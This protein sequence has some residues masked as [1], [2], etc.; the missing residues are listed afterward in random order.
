MDFKSEILS[1]VYEKNQEWVL[2]LTAKDIAHILNS[3]AYVPYMKKQKKVDFAANIGKQGE[4]KFEGIISQYMSNDY[5][6]TNTSK[7]AHSGDFFLTW[8]SPKTHKIYKILIDVKN[9]KRTSIS[10]KEVHKLHNDLNVNVVHA[11]FMISLGAK[12]TGFSKTIEI[13]EFVLDTGVKIP[14][15]FANI[16]TPETICEVLKLLFRM[17]EINDICGNKQH[18]LENLFY[19]INQL[20]DDIQLITD[21]RNVL[22][23]SKNKIDV[24]LNAI[25]H[26]LMT[27]EYSL[28]GKITKINNT[29]MNYQDE[30]KMIEP[31]V[32]DIPLNMLENVKR[33]FD[34]CP[35]V[36]PYLLSIFKIGWDSSSIDIPKKKWV[37]I[38]NNTTITIRLFKIMCSVMIPVI[39]DD[40]QQHI[41]AV[42]NISSKLVRNTASGL[43]IKITDDT[44]TSV[45]CIC[46]LIHG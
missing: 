41:N 46:K 13:T 28:A 39:T 29:I 2:G 33:V 14:V 4:N 43:D 37:L 27:C 12:I 17:V 21:T 44:I 35:E 25:M 42:R 20:N 5:K 31:E 11:G 3:V 6:L 23:E 32:N 40:M 18:D 9:Y 30:L 45:I 10:T 34:V 24:S 16:K 36:Y 1:H 26:K 7:K 38:K 8:Q 22:Q 19:Q 15:I